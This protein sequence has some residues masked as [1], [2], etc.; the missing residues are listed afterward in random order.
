M[1]SKDVVSNLLQHVESLDPSSQG[2]GSL[3]EAAD[4]LSPLNLLFTA[5]QLV[6]D[7]M[8]AISL[9][10]PEDPT[11]QSYPW[12]KTVRKIF[13]LAVGL[14]S[15]FWL[16]CGDES[17][18]LEDRAHESRMQESL[19][20]QLLLKVKFTESDSQR[21]HL[22][23]LHCEQILEHDDKITVKVRNLEKKP[24]NVIDNRI[25]VAIR[26]CVGMFLLDNQS[27]RLG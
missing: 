26:K 9:D 20:Y 7:E 16:S 19:V 1:C 12:L 25:R 27:G 10:L 11:T 6:A 5:L 4:E 2:N 22:K 23:S 3:H 15:T 17:F 21:K 8:S 13:R 18:G 24:N 14:N